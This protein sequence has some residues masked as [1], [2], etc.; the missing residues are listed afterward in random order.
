M[1]ILNELSSRYETNDDTLG[2][3]G[4]EIKASRIKNNLTLKETSDKVCSVSYLCKIERNDINPNPYFLEKICDR[5][6]LD[7]NALRTLY[8]L[9]KYL[10][11]MTN[12]FYYNDSEVVEKSYNDIK[13]FD[14]YKASILKL[15]YYV[16][17]GDITNA[18][19]VNNML[20]KITSSMTT[21]DLITYAIFC[22]VLYYLNDEYKEA[23]TIFDRISSSNEIS[24]CGKGICNMYLLRIY[25]F[26]NSILFL[27]LV[28]KLKDFHINLMN[29][30]KFNETNFLEAKYYLQNDIYEEFLSIKPKLKNTIYEGSVE[31][32]DDAYNYR[33]KMLKNYKNISKF[34][35]LLGLYYVN[36]E[37]FLESVYNLEGLDSREVLYIKYLESTVMDKSKSF[38]LLDIE[39]FPTALKLNQ[40]YLVE[41][42]GSKLAKMFA[43]MTRYKLSLDTLNKVMNSKKE[44]NSK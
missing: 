35:R 1:K 2:V 7:Q 41:K 12:A 43:D 40:S 17:K 21:K 36:K 10:D 22:A 31:L 25:Y 19:E 37:A 42:A 8:N 24:E 30:E 6:S 13:D 23:K 28:L 27:P 15:I 18:I 11:K 3:L 20:D 32:L 29:Y 16:Y 34:Y 14:N 33:V 4:A 38:P 44:F 9:N 5:V 39:I 26:T